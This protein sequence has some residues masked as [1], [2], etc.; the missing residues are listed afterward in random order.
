[1]IL[2][3]SEILNGDIRS[4]FYSSVT[5]NWHCS[6]LCFCHGHSLFAL[7][8]SLKRL[9]GGAAE[10]VET[11]ETQGVEEA[12]VGGRRKSLQIFPA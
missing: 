2:L 10:S 4:V 6:I 12:A 3:D 11:Q 1:M 7:S 8:A 5:H 9:R